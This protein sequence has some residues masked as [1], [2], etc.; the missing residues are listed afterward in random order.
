M[1]SSIFPD[2]C[3]ISEKEAAKVSGLSVATFRRLEYAGKGPAVTRLSER[4]KGYRLDKLRAWLDA[5]T[6]QTTTA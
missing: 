6:E 3:I 2:D 1:T 4:R 5:H